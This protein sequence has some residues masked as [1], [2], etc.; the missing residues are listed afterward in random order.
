MIERA[1]KRISNQEIQSIKNTINMIFRSIRPVI[2][3]EREK[4]EESSK[5]EISQIAYKA[6]LAIQK[7]LKDCLMKVSYNVPT[8][9]EAHT[10]N[11]YQELLYN[12]S[13]RKEIYNKIKEMKTSQLEKGSLGDNTE[14]NEEFLIKQIL[15]L[16]RCV[17]DTISEKEYRVLKEYKKELM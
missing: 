6:E 1:N 7:I 14:K 2:Y 12:H 10:L 15:Y 17:V 16:Y 13:K 3:S 4:L 5:E 9:D 8:E 11:A